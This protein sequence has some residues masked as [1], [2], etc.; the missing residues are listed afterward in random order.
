[1]PCNLE[2]FQP[3]PHRQRLKLDPSLYF[4]TAAQKE[5]DGEAA[6]KVVGDMEDGMKE[7]I[8]QVILRR[9]SCGPHWES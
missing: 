1:M 7:Y 5:E 8:L 3:C 4:Q 9:V 6:V 2:N